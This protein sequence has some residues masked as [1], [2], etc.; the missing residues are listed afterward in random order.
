MIEKLCK[1]KTDVVGTIR[2]SRIGIPSDVIKTPIRKG[3][4]VAEFKNK[5]MIMKWKD[6]REV[7]FVSTVHNDNMMKI[8]KRKI[9]T[10]KPEVV[11]N[12][13][14]KMGGVD[15]SDGIII[16][17]SSA[18]KRLKKYYKKIF[19]HLLDIICLNAFILYKKNNG[20]LSRINFL[21]EFIEDTIASYPIQRE[22]ST[23]TIRQPTHHVTQLVGNHFSDYISGTSETNNPTR[24]CSLCYERKIRKKS[25][26]WCS[27]CKV[28]FKNGF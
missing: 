9:I 25:R 2:K 6:K 3:E 26:Y 11:I 17:Y 20:S 24:R 7:Y 28:P 1:H 15:L 16:A 23:Q 10:K 13:N 5:I 12:Y 27:I 18:R 4:Y 22:K 19:L 14:K 21:M 8:E